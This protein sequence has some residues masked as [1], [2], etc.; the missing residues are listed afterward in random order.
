MRARAIQ[1]PLARAISVQQC[2]QTQCMQ[3]RPGC[4]CHS[5]KSVCTHACMIRAPTATDHVQ[6]HPPALLRR[7]RMRG[8]QGAM[9]APPRSACADQSATHAPPRGACCDVAMPCATAQRRM[10]TTTHVSHPMRALPA[11]LGRSR[12]HRRGSVAQ[13][14]VTLEDLAVPVPAHA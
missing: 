5:L 2:M 4:H 14:L 13:C 3:T 1:T 6:S 11:G 7:R 12:P 8:A 9:H 10:A